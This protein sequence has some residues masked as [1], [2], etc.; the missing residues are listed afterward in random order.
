MVTVL[1]TCTKFPVTAD[2]MVGKVEI[3]LHDLILNPGMMHQQISTLAGADSGSS[4]PGKLHWEVGFF[5]KPDFRPALRTSGKDVNLPAGLEDRPELQ[6]DQGVLENALEDAVMHTPPDPL[7]PSG[8]VS[9]VVHQIVNLETRSLKGNYGSRKNGKEY[10][11]GME[12]G[13][14]KQEEGGKLPSAYCTIAL[15]D[16]LVSTPFFIPSLVSS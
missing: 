10:S 6:D 7:W 14:I 9:L 1:D 15:N 11:P 5:G 13:E 3:S 2:D 4:M 16:Q 8:I 12:T